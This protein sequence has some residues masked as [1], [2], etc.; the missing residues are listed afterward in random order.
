MAV[1]LPIYMDHHATTPVDPRVVEAM[2]PYFTERF[3]NAASRNHS[4]GWEAEEAVENARKQVADLIKYK[5]GIE[6]REVVLGH[7]QRGGSP[8]AYDRVLG[9]RLGIHARRLAL[10]KDFGKMVA[11][12]G[13]KIVSVPLAEAVGQMRTLPPEFMDEVSEFLR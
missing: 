7:L 5:T 3:G 9:T 6:T 2:L 8:S 10:K 13:I 12:R 11:L 1:K 4:F